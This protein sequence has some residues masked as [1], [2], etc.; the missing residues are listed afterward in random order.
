M[1]THKVNFVLSMFFLSGMILSMPCYSN[2][3]SRFEIIGDYYGDLASEN[4]TLLGGDIIK[5]NGIFNENINYRVVVGFTIGLPYNSF[6]IAVFDENTS[7][8]IILPFISFYY[9]SC[10]SCASRPY[11]Q[12]NLTDAG[13]VEHYTNPHP[14]ISDFIRQSGRGRMDGIYTSQSFTPLL[15]DWELYAFEKFGGES[16]KFLLSVTHPVPEQTSLSLMLLGLFMLGILQRISTPLGDSGKT[17]HR[18]PSG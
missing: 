13:P 10:P 4:L 15:V 12:L 6:P 9:G 18:T 5:S 8:N 16:N 2:V 1:R 3:I 14:Q 17:G 11:L 7:Q